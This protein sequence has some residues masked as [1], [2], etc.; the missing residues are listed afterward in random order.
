MNLFVIFP[1]KAAFRSKSITGVLQEKSKKS[2]VPEIEG[3][4]HFTRT[5]RV[6]RQFKLDDAKVLNVINNAP[7][8]GHYAFNVC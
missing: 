1:D 4:H 6:L 2:D 8:Y 3:L 7:L 5:G